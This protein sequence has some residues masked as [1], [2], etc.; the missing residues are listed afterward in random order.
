MDGS[1]AVAEQ[2]SVYRRLYLY[3]RLLVGHGWDTAAFW[4]ATAY[5]IYTFVVPIHIQQRVLLAINIDPHHRLAIWGFGLA[6]FVLYAGFRAW[7][8]EC[9]HGDITNRKLAE[10]AVSRPRLSGYITSTPIIETNDRHRLYVYLTIRNQGLPSAVDNWQLRFM[11][12]GNNHHITEASLSR[13]AHG[14]HGDTG[15]LLLDDTVIQPGGKHS[16]WLLYDSPESL[17]GLKVPDLFV[18]FWDTYG[19]PY[20][21]S[22]M[23]R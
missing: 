7:S 11:L 4:I 17:L 20:S 21:A 18:D 22:I 3:G 16:G 2:A 10:A 13:G 5:S 1:N 6:A 12:R 14:S 8:S 15:N 19:N 9:L 23:S